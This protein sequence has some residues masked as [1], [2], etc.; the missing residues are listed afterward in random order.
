MVFSWLMIL[1]TRSEVAEVG[2]APPGAWPRLPIGGAPASAPVTEGTPTR[3]GDT[4][5]ALTAGTV[6]G[7]LSGPGGPATRAACSAGPA[8]CCTQ[9]CG[10]E[11]IFWVSG[12][13]RAP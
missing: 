2:V 11:I 3:P 13:T 8:C 1:S 7:A 5:G 4:P 10:P 6:V 12:S 9:P